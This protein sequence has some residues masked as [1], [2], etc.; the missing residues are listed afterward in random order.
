VRLFVSTVLFATAAT[1]M[2]IMDLGAQT[3]PTAQGI[4]VAP[5]TRVRV[6]APNLVAPLIANFL[7]LNADTAV[8][9]EDAAGRGIWSIRVN[10]ISR[11]ER[12]DGEKRMNAPYMLRGGLMGAGIG[13]AT[14]LLFAATFKPS[15]D[16][17][18]YDRLTTGL[19]GAGAGAVIGAM[20]GGRVVKE[21]WVEIPLRRLSVAPTKRGVSL[22]AGFDF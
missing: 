22:G 9:I 10:E 2:P 4:G 15:D 3:R 17:Q 11:L 7:N 14:G 21:K 19:V 13:A 12:S 1:L 18:K 6:R 20:L 8:F 5:G 16:T